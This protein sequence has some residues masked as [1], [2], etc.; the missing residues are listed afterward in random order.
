MRVSTDSLAT[1]RSKPEDRV[2][3]LYFGF[4][5]SSAL[6]AGLLDV[7]R[8]EHGRE[9][10]P[11]R[12]LDEMGT[13]TTAAP[14]AKYE[15]A[16]VASPSSLFVNLLKVAFGVK[17][18]RI[19]ENFGVAQHCPDIGEDNGAFGDEPTVINVVLHHSVG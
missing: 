14:K 19:W 7:Q 9:H 16:R 2:L 6:V 17:T 5:F 10:K 11:Y 8:R 18:L 15:D 4:Y 1:R 12:T 3:K 13:R